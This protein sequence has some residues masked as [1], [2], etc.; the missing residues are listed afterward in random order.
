MDTIFIN[1]ALLFALV[2]A[3]FAGLMIIRFLYDFCVEGFHWAETV[4]KIQIH[5]D[6]TIGLFVIAIFISWAIAEHAGLLQILGLGNA[7]GK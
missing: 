5:K 4:I 1:I 6:L 7:R 2:V 3:I